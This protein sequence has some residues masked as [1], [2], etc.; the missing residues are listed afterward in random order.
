MDYK[1]I[2]ESAWIGTAP[3]RIAIQ[4]RSK[5]R[6]TSRGSFA[7]PRFAKVGVSPKKTNGSNCDPSMQGT[8]HPDLKAADKPAEL[9]LERRKAE[10][11]DSM[12][13]RRPGGMTGAPGS[14]L[15]KNKREARSNEWVS[16]N[17]GT[18]CPELGAWESGG[19]EFTKV[20][21]QQR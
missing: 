9:A 17:R 15:D 10:G 12:T 5:G 14:N 20:I 2:N 8:K 1:V 21:R 3:R 16:H 13:N 6:M 11:L 7:I 18:V 4:P 19:V